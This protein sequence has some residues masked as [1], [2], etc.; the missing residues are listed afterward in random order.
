MKSDGAPYIAS[1][2]INYA[3]FV[4]TLFKKQSEEFM[5]FHCSGGICGEAGELADVIKRE[6][7]YEVNTTAE[8][9]PILE[10]ITEECGDVLWYLQATMNRYNL[11]WDDIIEYNYAKLGKRYDKLVYTDAAAQNRAD[12][13]AEELTHF[14]EI[15]GTNGERQVKNVTKAEFDAHIA[16]KQSAVSFLEQQGGSGEVA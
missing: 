7:N 9:K 1:V 8:G 10:G 6:L 14:I 4:E 12:K 16:N 11:S 3:E 2:D 5:K 15:R 13:K